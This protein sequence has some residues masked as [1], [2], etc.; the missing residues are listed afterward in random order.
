M[1]LKM[2]NV[3]Q[4]KRTAMFY[5]VEDAN[6]SYCLRLL[7][8]DILDCK[9]NLKNEPEILHVELVGDIDLFKLPG[10]LKVAQE[11]GLLVKI[12]HI[13]QP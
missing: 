12:E 2:E 3:G 1:I 8:T 5:G 10:L 7:L 13:D 4:E 11:S 6:D 9:K